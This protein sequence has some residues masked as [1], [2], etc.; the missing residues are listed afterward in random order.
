MEILN[1]ENDVT[2][3]I[4]EDDEAVLQH[5]WTSLNQSGFHCDGVKSGREAIAKLKDRKYKLILLDYLLPDMSGAQFISNLKNGIK[6]TPF[7]IMTS[8]GDERIAIEMMKQGARDYLVKDEKFYDLLPRV[9][10]R[11]DQQIDNEIKLNRA[12]EKLREQAKLI[13][14][15]NDAIVVRNMEDIVLF[16]NKAAE[17]LYG[18]KKEEAVGRK[19]IEIFYKDEFI[20]VVD[21]ENEVISK[22]EWQGEL[23]QTTKEGETLTVE[24]HQTLIR[25]ETGHPKSILIINRDITEKKQL[26]VQFLRSQRMEGIGSLAGGIAHDL[27]N[28]L[29]PISLS[30]DLLLRNEMDDKSREL[31]AVIKTSVERTG[32]VVHQVLAFARGV[33]NGEHIIIQPKP[34]LKE[35]ANIAKKTFPKNVSVFLKILNDLW[36]IKGDPTQIHQVLLNLCVNARDAMS[37]GG[38]LILGAENLHMDSQFAS[39][40]EKAKAGP[41][42]KFT[43]SDTGVG[44]LAETKERIFDPFFTTKNLSEGTGL[45]LSTAHGIVES[46][47]GFI[48]VE[49]E[50][51]QGSTFNIFIP[52]EESPSNIQHTSELKSNLPLVNGDLILL[53]DDNL[54]FQKVTQETLENQG[55]KVLLAEDGTEALAQFTKHGNDVKVMITD[56]A[57]PHLDG[58]TLVR[59]LKRMNSDLKFIVSTGLGEKATIEKLEDLGVKKFLK[60]PYNTDTL[61]STL[62]EVM[63]TNSASLQ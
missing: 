52:A 46:L 22:G 16:M 50:V 47:G 20:E 57:M 59:T 35:V 61:I 17:Q 33:E 34:V 2:L 49:S 36:L 48:S 13:D 27:N 15:A 41:Y 32:S 40:Y 30:S 11:V 29:A 7:I 39:T 12:E 58:T 63:N 45:G 10:S 37:E 53:V 6:K 51:N 18:H 62:H 25:D 3:L 1:M 56:I 9:V 14:I 28:L 60:K 55:Y 24:S 54:E 5:I 4:A 31:I 44:M 23:K 42:V 43:I 38:D 19:S 26:E 8:H 21:A